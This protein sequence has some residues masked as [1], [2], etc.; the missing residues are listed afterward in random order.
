MPIIKLPKSIATVDA[1]HRALYRVAAECS[2]DICSDADEWVIELKPA[3]GADPEQLERSFREH[4]IDYGLRE[5]VR[6]ETEQVRALLL[7]HAFSGV[8]TQ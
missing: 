7:A 5:K 4:I 6:A 1:I 2:W 8:T 3:D